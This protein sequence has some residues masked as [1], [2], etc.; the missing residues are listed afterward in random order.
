MRTRLGVSLPTLLAVA[1]LVPACGGGGSPTGPGANPTPT[2]A[3]GSPVSGVVFYDENGN[4]GLDA[5]QDVRL[6]GVTV[7][8]GGRTGRSTAGG[9]FTVTG[10]PAGA[11]TARAQSLPPYFLAGNGATVTVPQAAGSPVF[12]PAS[13]PIGANR[14]S[15]FVAFGDSISAGEG[16]SDDGGYRS[17]LEAELRAYWGEAELRNQGLSGTRSNAGDARIDGVLVR[18]RPAYTLI[19]YGTNDWNELECKTSPPCFTIDSLRS[20]IL[21][22]RGRNSLPIV[23]TIPPVNTTYTDRAPQERQDWVRQMNELVRPMV[24]QEGAIL[25]DIHAAM[26]GAGDVTALFTDHVHPNDRGYQIIGHEWFRAITTASATASATTMV[27]GE[28]AEAGSLFLAP[29]RAGAGASHL[30]DRH[31]RPKR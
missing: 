23:G 22:T 28:P 14:A 21:Q 25:A 17:W 16:S 4:G 30:A 31:A 15:R 7:N 18:E 6:P 1:A 10:V 12:V 5:G 27:M 11:Q 24:S 9:E 20:M 13:L 3:T 2:P 29:A 19:L 26:M 8:V